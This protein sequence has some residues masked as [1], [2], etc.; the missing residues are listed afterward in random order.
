MR[1]FLIICGCILYVVSPIDL[2]VD[3]I[4]VLGWLDDVAIVVMTIRAMLK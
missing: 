1:K 3:L 2:V 4:P